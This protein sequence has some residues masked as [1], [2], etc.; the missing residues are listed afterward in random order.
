MERDLNAAYGLVVREIHFH[1][2]VDESVVV[3][4]GVKS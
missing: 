4:V 2:N 3:R 1:G